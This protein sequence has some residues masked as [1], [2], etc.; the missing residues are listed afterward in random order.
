MSTYRATLTGSGGGNFVSISPLVKRDCDPFL[1]RFL[2]N[3][4]LDVNLAD[5]INSRLWSTSSSSSNQEVVLSSF[6]MRLL[7]LQD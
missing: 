4:S 7:V 2:S 1:I 3:H 6:C 5:R